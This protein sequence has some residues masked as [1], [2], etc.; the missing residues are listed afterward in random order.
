M[1]ENDQSHLQAT[2][3]DNLIDIFSFINKILDNKDI[4]TDED[5]I[6]IFKKEFED[7]K[8]NKDIT[9]KFH[10]YLSV[11][12]ELIQLYQQ[13]D[14]NPEM[15]I[16]KVEKILKESRIEIKNEK[17]TDLVVFK[18]EYDKGKTINANE[19]EELRNKLLMSSTN[20]RR[21]LSKNYIDLIDDI[22]QLTK[23]LNSLLKLGY[24][25]NLNL[26]FTVNNSNAILEN[27]DDRIIKLGEVV[28]N[29]KKTNENFKKSIK[30]GYEKSPYLRLFYEKQFVALNTKAVGKPIDISHL[31][32]SV[33][34]NK[35]K[36]I[37]IDFNYNFENSNSV[38]NTNKFIE[39][40][41]KSNKVNINDIY[42]KNKIL[43]NIDLKPGLYRKVKAGDYCY[44]I[45]NILN[46]Y[47]NIT[48]NLPLGNT[49][50]ICNE[51][52]TIEKIKAFL[53]RALFCESPVL[54]AISNI[55]CLDFSVTQEMIRTL[56]SLYKEKNKNINS[57]LL[58]LYEKVQSGF[59]RDIE[60][61]IPKKNILRN[62]F[63][64]E[65]LQNYEELKKIELYSSKFS[66]YGKTTEIFYKVKDL[67]G[68]YY[69]IPIGGS[70]SRD[71]VLNN[72]ENL[73]LNFKN[74]KNIYLHIDL[75]ETD[76]D[77]LMNEI[78]FKLL[79][80]KYIDSYEKVFYLGNEINI[81]IEIPKG[82]VEFDKKYNLLNLFHKVI[83]NEL[84][85]LRLEPDVKYIKDLPISIVSVVLSLYKHKKIGKNNI[86]LDKPITKNVAEYEKI[87]NEYFQVENQNY[88]QK[89][90]F[91]KILSIQFK[92]FTNSYFLNYES[93]CDLGKG[94]IIQK[95][96]ISIIRNFIELTKVFSR[97]PFDTILVRQD[98]SRKLFGK[99]DDSQ[100]KKEGIL[101]LANEIQDVF[102][103]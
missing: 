95:A 79:I 31:I 76:N 102:F 65:S 38:Q 97:S 34:L 49:I 84:R 2:D 53:Y 7:E 100:A 50:L 9:V 69:Y 57:Y 14:E 41:F 86:D 52:T 30:E 18:I 12:D 51:E 61:I 45:N 72:L 46:I 42:D 60:K 103:I 75:S 36:N 35:I 92:K 22:K 54:F 87:I 28:N 78:L 101:A 17:D 68:E 5:F 58:F 4:K 47:I 13:Y 64:K 21:D 98:H 70:F 11:F 90:N 1:D 66:G 88:Y 91:V 20:N 25:N 56:K 63:T 16:E 82:F 55:E 77:E 6:K 74:A 19:L 23:T 32:N 26:V 85:P 93:A 83:I 37:Q 33:S 99:Y 27:D 29:F 44:M 94:E 67:K 48:G 73:H 71:Y 81:I 3:I 89:M 24:P 15:T 62:E 80:L 43:E 39:K 8:N 59:V 40:L 96:R 10:S